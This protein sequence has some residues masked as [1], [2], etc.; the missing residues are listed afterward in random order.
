[1]VL[2]GY[3]IYMFYLIKQSGAQQGGCFLS[4]PTS[5]I[6]HWTEGLF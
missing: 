6:H 4:T 5:K 3:L 1:M 2:G